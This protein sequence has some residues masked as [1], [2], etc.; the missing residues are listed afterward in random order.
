MIVPEHRELGPDFMDGNSCRIG[1][2]NCQPALGLPTIR[3]VVHDDSR[4]RI[5][6]L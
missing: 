6:R 3:S 1:L 5:E 4:Q 2:K